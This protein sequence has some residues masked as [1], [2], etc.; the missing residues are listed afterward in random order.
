MTTTALTDLPIDFRERAVLLRE[1]GAAEGVA[2]A[3]ERAA[4]EVESA[5]RAHGLE[6][7]TLS[8][9]ASESGYGVDHLR[10]LI[11]D[12]TIPNAGNDRE[13]RVLRRHLPKKPGHAVASA[14]PQVAS[15]RTQAAR[16]VVTGEE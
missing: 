14:G 5:L 9:A 1:Y 7:L 13:Y 2:I 16:A 3:W 6:A 12:G 11:R 10:R 15:S 8:E 4:T